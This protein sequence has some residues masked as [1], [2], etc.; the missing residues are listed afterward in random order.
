MEVGAVPRRPPGAGRLPRQFR[1]LIE[2]HPSVPAEYRID[3]ERRVVYS[4][5][6]GLLTDEDLVDYQLRL[7]AD[8]DFRPHYSQLVDLTGVEALELSAEGVRTSAAAELWSPEA[9]RAFV[10]PMDAAYGM[11]RMHEALSG[12]ENP[13][14][15]VFRCIAEAREWLRA[16]LQPEEPSPGE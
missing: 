7:N 15:R 14:V 1:H 10:A 16:T 5:G 8:P 6:W 9:R 4:R 3:P 11:V 13:N 2:G 12:G